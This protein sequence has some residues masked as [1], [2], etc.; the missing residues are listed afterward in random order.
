MNEELI[1]KLIEKIE[2]SDRTISNINTKLYHLDPI[3]G[4]I[5]EELE[6]LN[7]KGLKSL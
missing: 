2:E 1:E 4:G 5:L 7:K 3:F 6:S